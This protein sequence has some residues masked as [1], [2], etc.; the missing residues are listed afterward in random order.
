MRLRPSVPRSNRSVRTTVTLLYLGAV[1][2]LAAAI[3]I[4]T[5]VGD[6][7]SNVAE[8]NPALSEAEWHA[9]VAGQLEPTAVAA[10]IAAGLWLLMAWALG[11][12]HRWVRI[13]LVL[14]FGVNASGLLNGL[15]HGS[16]LYARQDLAVGIALC[17]VQL[18]AVAGSFRQ[19]LAGSPPGAGPF[20]P[21]S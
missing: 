2:E 8:A 4:L 1:A 3:T 7:R 19:K 20:T 21:G 14:F 11:R 15:I 10:G 12:G 5:T 17:L 6:V 13:A 9:V 16:A 18:A